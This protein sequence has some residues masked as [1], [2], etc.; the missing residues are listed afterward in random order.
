MI[1]LRYLG[2]AVGSWASAVLLGLLPA[3]LLLW[4]HPTVESFGVPDSLLMILAYSTAFSWPA[5]FLLL[6]LLG[7]IHALNVHIRVRRGIL[8]GGS[9]L[10]CAAVFAW[11]YLL[12]PEMI[13][14]EA[15]PA[16]LLSACVSVWL[17]SWNYQRNFKTDDWHGYPY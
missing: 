8:I 5:I 17:L 4:N 16:Y 12:W 14:L 10:I 2:I 7:V 3:I 13:W 9:A 6:A 1:F 15:S 11:T